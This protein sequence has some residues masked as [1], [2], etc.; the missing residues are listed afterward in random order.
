[1]ALFDIADYMC[2]QHSHRIRAEERAGIINSDSAEEL[3]ATKLKAHSH[4]RQRS[5]LKWQ[6]AQF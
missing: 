1:L 3:R 2:A 4:R 6:F 5:E